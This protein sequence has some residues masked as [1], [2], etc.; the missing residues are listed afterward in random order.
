MMNN[1][2]K[3]KETKTTLQKQAIVIAVVSVLI[4]LGLIFYF[5]VLPRLEQSQVGIGELYEG[6]ALDASGTVL[7]MVEP[8]TRDKIA[9]IE[10]KNS[11]GIY[12]LNEKG[13]GAASLAECHP[14]TEEEAREGHATRRIHPEGENYKVYFRNEYGIWTM[15][16]KPIFEN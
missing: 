16:M 13:K 15:P 14:L 5:A 2:P 9:K 12:V 7:Y 1:T 10:V 11:T 3:A 8:L 4:V 6:E